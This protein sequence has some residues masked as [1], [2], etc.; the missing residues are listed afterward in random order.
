MFSKPGSTASYDKKFKFI[1]T[2]I[3]FKN[4]SV[5]LMYEDGDI[6]QISVNKNVIDCR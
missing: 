2:E 5:S 6:F 1:K 4:D 3:K